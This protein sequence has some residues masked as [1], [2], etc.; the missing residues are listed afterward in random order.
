MAESYIEFKAVTRDEQNEWVQLLQK[1]M[2]YA[3]FHATA[4]PI[5]SLAGLEDDSIRASPSTDDV[6]NRLFQIYNATRHSASATCTQPLPSN[7]KSPEQ[8]SV[9]R[10]T[11]SNG[12]QDGNGRLSISQKA[13]RRLSK[14]FNVNPEDG[15]SSPKARGS[16]NELSLVEQYYREQEQ[17]EKS[18]EEKR[19][20]QSYTLGEGISNFKELQEMIM[21]ADM[22]GDTK[23]DEDSTTS[24]DFR[25]TSDNVTIQDEGGRVLTSVQLNI[26]PINHSQAETL[27][28]DQLE[29]ETLNTS[30]KRQKMPTLTDDGEFAKGNRKSSVFERLVMMRKK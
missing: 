12:H 20:S 17:M 16:G 25:T 19:K 5:I 23:F 11:I 2:V 29:A 1:A 28:H 24:S 18:R 8:K 6:D 26:P 14:V 10:R 3:R 7:S 9:W 21:H 30:P 4:S 27:F 22:H 13:I 15:K